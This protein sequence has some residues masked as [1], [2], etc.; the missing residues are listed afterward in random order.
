MRTDKIGLCQF[1]EIIP[2]VMQLNEV[3]QIDLM[4]LICLSNYE[5][6]LRYL[7]KNKSTEKKFLVNLLKSIAFSKYS[8]HKYLSIEI[9]DMLLRNNYENLL[10]IK[11]KIKYF[12]SDFSIVVVQRIVEK[13]LK[14]IEIVKKI[15][16]DL[17]YT[18]ILTLIKSPYESNRSNSTKLIKF[19]TKE[20]QNM[21]VDML[22]IDQSYRVRYNLFI[23]NKSN[24]FLI[25][26]LIEKLKNDSVGIIREEIYNCKEYFLSTRKET[27]LSQL[28][29]TKN[30][31]IKYNLIKN[32]IKYTDIFASDENILKF[33]M[34]EK[35]EDI[36][37][38]VFDLKDNT[39]YIEMLLESVIDTEYDRKYEKIVNLLKNI[40][41]V[42]DKII[43]NVTELLTHKIHVVRA[44]A[45]KVI[46]KNTRNINE[47]NKKRIV[48][49]EKSEKI[50]IRNDISELIKMLK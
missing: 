5:E 42:N 22:V 32:A 14:H 30:K 43:E 15:D 44:E 36:R 33:I 50:Q 39:K 31:T 16:D 7:H 28:S 47:K 2:Q 21:I 45:S 3:E 4:Y 48:A 38:C 24:G 23:N 18:L 46:R 6:L 19:L 8:M 35:D 11:N 1:E 9:I 17:I 10:F 27:I 13:T 40:G 12:V 26:N 41:Q 49:L 25:K 29:L 34:Q 37:Q 20:K